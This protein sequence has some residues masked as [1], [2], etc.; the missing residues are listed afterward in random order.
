LAGVQ[1]DNGARR[2]REPVLM[3]AL[4]NPKH[5]LFAQY[6]AKGMKDCDAYVEAGYKYNRGN[7]SA[8][9]TKENISARIEELIEKASDKAEISIERVLRELGRVGFQDPRNL[10]SKEGGIKGIHDLDQD[11]AAA[12]AS[13]ELVSRKSG[14][15]DDDGNPIYEQIHKVRTWDKVSA[16][17]KMARILGANIDKIEVTGPNGGPIEV[18]EETPRERI[19]SRIAGL[20]ARGAAAGNS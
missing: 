5:E 17:E 15:T 14:E 9:K 7:A 11:T 12:I 6:V 2:S 13:V 18:T 8:L 4:K 3:P 20:A 16:L 19:A 1:E 10:F